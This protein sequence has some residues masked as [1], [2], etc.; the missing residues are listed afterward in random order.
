MAYFPFGGRVPIFLVVF[1]VSAGNVNYAYEISSM[2]SQSF[3]QYRVQTTSF[4]Q[5]IRD[6]GAVMR[7]SFALLATLTVIALLVA[8]AGIY[9]VVVFSV[10]QRFHEIGIRMAPG[11]SR[12]DILLSVIRSALVQ[13]GI[14]VALGLVIAAFCAQQIRAQLFQTSPF[15]A[16]SFAMAVALTLVT[17]ALAAAVP[18]IRAARVQP[19]NILRYE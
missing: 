15:D 7:A 3:P 17:S 18:A 5:A 6:D 13:S 2:I 10:E 12:R 9:G 19:A 8:V 14:G 1:R 11:A 4:E 16:A